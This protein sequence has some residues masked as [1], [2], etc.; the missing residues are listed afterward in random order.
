MAAAVAAAVVVAAVAAAVQPQVNGV[1]AKKKM[2]DFP[3]SLFFRFRSF[4]QSLVSV[5]S[6]IPLCHWDKCCAGE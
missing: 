1:A 3:F 4:L 2:P 6:F 5:L